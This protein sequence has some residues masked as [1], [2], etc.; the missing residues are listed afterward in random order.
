MN[1]LV[2]LSKTDEQINNVLNG[3]A[4]ALNACGV[5][6]IQ[7]G[8]GTPLFEVLDKYKPS[9]MILSPDSINKAMV[10][11]HKEFNPETWIMFKDKD[12][13]KTKLEGAKEIGVLCDSD[14]E[15]TD[16]EYYIPF[17]ADIINYNPGKRE[18]RYESVN[19]YVGRYNAKF[20]EL[21]TA[22]GSSLRIYSP[23]LWNSLSYCGND[24]NKPA[25]YASSK[26][27]ILN[28]AK[29]TDFFN[30]MYSGATISSDIYNCTDFTSM[31]NGT[32]SYFHRANELLAK[33]GGHNDLKLKL[34]QKMKEVEDLYEKNRTSTE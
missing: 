17:G 4:F 14:T 27:V 30:V 34:E 9:L 21:F 29:D 20:E 7:W 15:P 10:K 18:K 33:V 32:H 13:I 16:G 6:I 31:V 26:N 28:S 12:D 24:N 1:I 23:D 22:L 5:N 3:Y 25:I 8:G 19:S 11:A 2:V